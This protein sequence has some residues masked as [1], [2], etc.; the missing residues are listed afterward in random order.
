MVCKH[1][2]VIKVS[3][4]SVKCNDC[5]SVIAFVEWA[6]FVQNEPV[7]CKHVVRTYITDSVFRCEVCNQ[8]IEKKKE[9]DYDRIH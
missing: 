6:N 7:S 4:D 2:S 9:R 1:V 5:N 3:S 8:I